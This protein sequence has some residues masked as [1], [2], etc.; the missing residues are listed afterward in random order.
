MAGQRCTGHCQGRRGD[1]VQAGQRGGPRRTPVRRFARLS[2]RGRWRR[3]GGRCRRPPARRDRTLRRFDAGRAVCAAGSAAANE[4]GQNCDQHGQ[5][6][7][8]RPFLPRR[9]T[10]RLAAHLLVSLHG[11]DDLCIG[12]PRLGKPCNLLGL[13]SRDR[14]RSVGSIPSRLRGGSRP[15]RSLA[16]TK[17]EAGRQLAARHPRGSLKMALETIAVEGHRFSSIGEQVLLAADELRGSLEDFVRSVRPGEL[18]TSRGQ[19]TRE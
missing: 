15:R 12:P 14:E 4:K 19:P 7:A 16:S 17:G 13:A 18:G 11:R 1:G 8:Q 9:H 10:Q 3:L 6:D 2:M 5:N